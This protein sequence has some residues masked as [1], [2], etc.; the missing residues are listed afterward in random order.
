MDGD[1]S[2][3]VFTLPDSPH[4][5]ALSFP[6]ADTTKSTTKR[7]RSM[8]ERLIKQSF[9]GLSSSSDAAILA[10]ADLNRALHA[11]RRKKRKLRRL[12]RKSRRLGSADSDD[13]L[14]ASDGT[15]RTRKHRKRE[16]EAPPSERLAS[17]RRHRE[18]APAKKKLRSFHAPLRS[19]KLTP[20]QLPS[21]SFGA[22]AGN[23][24][25]RMSADAA[26]DEHHER[27]YW[28]RLSREEEEEEEEAAKKKQQHADGEMSHDRLVGDRDAE[29]SGLSASQQ[30]MDENDSPS[31]HRHPTNS[32][33]TSPPLD[34]LHRQRAPRRREEHSSQPSRSNQRLE[35]EGE[36][37]S[38][39][40]PTREGRPRKNSDSSS[41]HGQP[42]NPQ[43]LIQQFP[44]M[45]PEL[46]EKK[47]LYR[48]KCEPP[49]KCPI[50]KTSSE[51]ELT[52]LALSAVHIY[53]TRSTHTGFDWPYALWFRI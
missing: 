34:H 50:S 4:H 13:S 18:G 22:D 40:H 37:S 27:D 17:P 10:R 33:E 53:R 47:P 29:T 30:T 3:G 1:T 41:A 19:R 26:V 12:L 16:S 32:D 25:E 38:R 11:E 20:V 43:R 44:V 49:G 7:R 9:L 48:C 45:E 21:I 6:A 46:V 52:I 23:P 35:T 31:T 36:A 24:H 2:K 8:S 15:L 51:G 28:G 14:S 39:D 42:Q 5:P